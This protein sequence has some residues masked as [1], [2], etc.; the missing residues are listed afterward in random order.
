MT[1]HYQHFPDARYE[2]PP[3][4][5]ELW[6][7]LYAENSLDNLL[8]VFAVELRRHR[9]GFENGDVMA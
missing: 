7:L 4:L 3:E 2:T 9:I 1:F 6:H 8:G 5:I